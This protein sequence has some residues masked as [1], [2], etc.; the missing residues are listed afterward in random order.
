MSSSSSDDMKEIKKLLRFT[1][2]KILDNRSMIVQI[3]DHIKND[4]IDNDVF[5]S[6]SNSNSN[7]SSSDDGM[8]TDVPSSLSG[9]GS[10]ALVDKQGEDL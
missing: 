2:Q 4:D 7:Y 5:S 1:I 10:S 6:S 3:L 8:I 9:K